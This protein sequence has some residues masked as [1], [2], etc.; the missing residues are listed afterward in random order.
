MDSLT[1]MHEDAKSNMTAL[2]DFMVEY[3][4][5][6]ADYN[7]ATANIEMAKA[8]D[9]WNEKA[10][11]LKKLV[12]KTHAIAWKQLADAE[13]AICERI[14]ATNARVAFIEEKTSWD[15]ELVTL[16]K[17]SISLKQ[18]NEELNMKFS[19]LELLVLKLQEELALKNDDI[20][21]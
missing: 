8:Y 18:E 17:E 11:K 16:Q 13:T 10:I 9:L 21:T 6:K 19:K 20:K 2:V 1:N 3:K 15:A 14:H 4:S 12:K 7:D 5:R